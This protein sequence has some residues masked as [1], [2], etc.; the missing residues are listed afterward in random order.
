[1]AETVPAILVPAYVKWMRSAS[2]R[3][4]DIVHRGL[5][6][7]GT[8]TISDIEQVDSIVTLDVLVRVANQNDADKLVLPEADTLH[9]EY[10]GQ[11]YDVLRVRQRSKRLFMMRVEPYEEPPPEE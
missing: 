10:D 3:E 1:M 4:T 7:D 6:P 2:R 9:F 5:D 8:F 11:R